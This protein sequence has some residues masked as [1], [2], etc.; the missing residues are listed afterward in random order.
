MSKPKRP[1]RKRK[2]G[3]IAAVKVYDPF[4][5]S[6][7]VKQFEQRIRNEVGKYCKQY[8]DLSRQR[9]LFRAVEIAL[10]A[11]KAFKPGLGSFATYVTWR[12]K[13]LHRLHD[14]DEKGNTSPV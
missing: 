13:E 2:P 10:A 3:N 7:L 14:E 11:E 8:P 9:L 5:R 1:K 12:L 6:G 4:P